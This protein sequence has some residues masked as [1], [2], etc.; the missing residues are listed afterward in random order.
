MDIHISVK[1]NSFSWEGQQQ[2]FKQRGEFVCEV[3]ASGYLLPTGTSPAGFMKLICTGPAPSLPCQVP[4][5]CM[6]MWKPRF[7]SPPS[8]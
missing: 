6:Y 2:L 1:F 4:L 3:L 5:L 8:S 7:V